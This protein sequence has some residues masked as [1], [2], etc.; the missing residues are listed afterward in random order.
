MGC[1]RSHDRRVMARLL[2]LFG[3]HIRQVGRI[4]E[5]PE[6]IDILPLADTRDLDKRGA[7]LGLGGVLR[8]HYELG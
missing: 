4:N 6:G 7:R 8:A 3:I 5:L 1:N 2:S